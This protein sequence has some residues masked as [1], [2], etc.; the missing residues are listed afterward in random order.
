MIVFV[1]SGAHLGLLDPQDQNHVEAAACFRRL[2]DRRLVTSTAVL[3]E[4]ATRG[5]R[6]VG[7]RPVA[8]Y[9]RGVLSSP[10]YAVPE[11]GHAFFAEAL[12][13]LAKYEDQGLSFTDCTTAILMRAGRIRTVFTF[14]RAFRRLG[15]QVVP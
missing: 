12:D 1:D 15:F 5:A 9:I 2:E 3:A 7:A 4:V 6:L 10:L 13:A 14:D 11:V 8:D